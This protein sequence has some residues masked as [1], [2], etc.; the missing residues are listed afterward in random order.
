MALVMSSVVPVRPKI[1]WEIIRAD[2]QIVFMQAFQ[3]LV[4]GLEVAAERGEISDQTY[5]RMMREFLP[6][7]KSSSAEAADA[8]RDQKKREQNQIRFQ[9]ALPAPQNGNPGGT[10]VAGPGQQ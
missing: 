6:L 4:M 1:S 8:D 7:M 10:P 3:Q 2:D 5:R 9:Q